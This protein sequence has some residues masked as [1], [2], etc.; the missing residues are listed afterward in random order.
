M[1]E[2]TNAQTCKRDF[3]RQL[4]STVSALALLAIYGTTEA[5]ADQDA[6]RPTV[7]IELGGQ[8]EQIG[9]DQKAFAPPFSAVEP[10]INVFLARK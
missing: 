10:E 9:T 5:W 1:S 8:F 2:L 7:W 3:Q 6:D 4:L